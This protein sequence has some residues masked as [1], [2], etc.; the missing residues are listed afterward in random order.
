MRLLGTSSGYFLPV[1]VYLCVYVMALCVMS[2]CVCVVSVCVCDIS[3]CVCY[4]CVYVYIHICVVSVYTCVCVSTYVV[5]VSRICVYVC[6]SISGTG[7]QAVVTTSPMDGDGTL[8]GQSGPCTPHHTPPPSPRPTPSPDSGPGEFLQTQSGC[9]RA[10]V[11]RRRSVSWQ[12]S[13]RTEGETP[14]NGMKASLHKS[15]GH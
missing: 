14:G 13:P 3:V 1:C 15:T 5:C 10:R 12:H 4:I 6:V 7:R 11:C 2:V 9:D 8:R